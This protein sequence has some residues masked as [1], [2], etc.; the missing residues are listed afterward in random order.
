MHLVFALMF[1][2]H[3][4]P[5]RAGYWK[6]NGD[7][8]DYY[9]VSKLDNGDRDRVCGVVTKDET[10]WDVL[11]LKSGGAKTG[12]DGKADNFDLAKYEVEQDCH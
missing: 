8:N 9:I 4:P 5:V 11:T 6:V 7:E 10:G 2:K 3:M 12:F 1:I